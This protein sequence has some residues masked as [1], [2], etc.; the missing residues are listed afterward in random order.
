MKAP[1]NKTK[2]GVTKIVFSDNVQLVILCY[3]D[4][5]CAHTD[6]FL[7]SKLIAAYVSCNISEVVSE[8]SFD[9]C[10]H[11][12]RFAAS[13]SVIIQNTSC[14]ETAL[15]A[16]LCGGDFPIVTQLVK[17]NPTVLKFNPANFLPSKY[18]MVYEICM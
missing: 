10:N 7:L 5:F 8:M 13:Y 15:L 1:N 17:F 2:A 11:W 4:E 9:D 12:L 16:N 6:I 3:R 14:P 18:N